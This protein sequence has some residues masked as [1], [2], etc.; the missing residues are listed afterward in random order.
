[1]KFVITLLTIGI[2]MILYGIF[3]MQPQTLENF[4]RQPEMIVGGG[5]VVVLAIAGLIGGK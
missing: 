5:F 2:S 4:S 3:G 1:M